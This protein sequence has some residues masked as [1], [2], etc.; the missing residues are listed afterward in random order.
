M[1]SSGSGSSSAPDLESDS[2]SEDKGSFKTLRSE[3]QGVEASASGV[4]AAGGADPQVGVGVWAGLGEVGV[5]KGGSEE[6]CPSSS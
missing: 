2:S 6:E 5:R 3:V 1:S 4:N